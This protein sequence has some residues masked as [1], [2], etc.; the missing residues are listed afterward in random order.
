MYPESSKSCKKKSKT[1]IN[2]KNPTTAM[3]PPIIPSLSSPAQSGDTSYVSSQPLMIV[4]PDSN[5]PTNVSDKKGPIH[6]WD[7]EN[8]PHMMNAKITNPKT[9]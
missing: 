5:Q 2:G 9:G 4:A 6:N 1:I 7:K 8:I 3:N